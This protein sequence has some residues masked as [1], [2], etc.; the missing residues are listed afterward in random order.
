MATRFCIAINS[1]QLNADAA[2]QNCY[3]MV[4]VHFASSQRRLPAIVLITGALMMIGSGPRAQPPSLSLPINCTPGTDCWLVNL[5][6]HD[7]N[8]GVRDFRCTDHGYNGHKGTDIAI[9]DLSAMRA[10]VPVLAAAPGVVTALRDGMMDRVPS[11]EF[12]RTKRNLFCGNGVVVRHADGWE[13]QYCH[14]RQGSVVV[15]RGQRLDRGQQIGLVGH[16]GMATFPHIHLSV[17]HRKRV[18]DPFVGGARQTAC[19][20]GEAPLWTVAAIQALSRPL[21]AVYNI[22]FAPKSP[23]V[24]LIREGLYQNLRLSRRA[25]ALVLWAEVFWVEAGD[26]VRFHVT[27][28]NGAS[29]MDYSN[30]LS[31]REARRVIFAGRKKRGM[32]WPTGKYTGEI[33]IER[34]VASGQTQRFTARS[35]VEIMDQRENYN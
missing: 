28:P 23:K 19:Q 31:N 1:Y 18:I 6:D 17:R 21:T 25:P 35:D 11:A 5:V 33:V 30:I 9:R 34:L 16:S 4:M 27:G 26:K 7:P 10:G 12:Q 20:A 13:T 8:T 15:K 22:G 14:L 32:F 2:R 29:I 3:A 24:R